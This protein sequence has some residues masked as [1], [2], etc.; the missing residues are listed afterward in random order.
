MYACVSETIHICLH[1]CIYTSQ[2]FIDAMSPQETCQVDV[3]VYTPTGPHP[4]MNISASC[5]FGSCLQLHLSK[6]HPFHLLDLCLWS[7]LLC[8]LL[9][10]LGVFHLTHHCL[11]P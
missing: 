4:V 5:Y 7:H 1:I 11:D 9:T 3:S 10:V 8:L 6:R 2:R